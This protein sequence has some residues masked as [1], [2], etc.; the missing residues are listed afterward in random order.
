M[1]LLFKIIIKSIKK[2]YEEETFLYSSTLAFNLI[3]TSIPIVLLLFA[4]GGYFLNLRDDILGNLEIFVNQQFPFAKDFIQSNIQYLITKSGLV[5]G[6]SIIIL[7]WTVSRVFLTFRIVFFEIFKIP[8]P[9]KKWLY[10][11]KESISV[12]ILSFILIPFLFINSLLFTLKSG[13]LGTPLQFYTIPLFTEVVSFLNS[14]LLIFIIYIVVVGFKENIKTIITGTFLSSL[15]LEIIKIVFNIF[16]TYLWETKV[17]YGS[18]W[19]TFALILLVYYSSAG[20]II[21]SIIA[22]E[23]KKVENW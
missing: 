17:I 10:R 15:F 19:V 13:L 21:G 5:G 12:V 4:F 9:E 8:Q 3:A 7:I 1:K 22:E 23:L 2:Y 16:V 14:F 6:L 20:I 18:L 11:L